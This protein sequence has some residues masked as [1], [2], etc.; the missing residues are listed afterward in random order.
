V[1]NVLVTGG[2][3]FIGSALVRELLTRGVGVTVLDDLSTG[4][5]ENLAGLEDRIR[6]VRGD[7]AS[8]SICAASMSGVDT[9]FHLAAIASVIRSFG[10]LSACHEVNMTGTVNLMDAARDAGARRFVHAVSAAAFGDNPSLPLADDAKAQPISPY[11]LHKLGAEHYGRILTMSG[12]LD[13]VG[14]RYFNIFGPRQDPEGDYAAVIP[15]FITRML[16]GQAPIIFGDG[17]QTRDFL[18]VEDVARAN[19]LAAD[20][21]D[22]PGMVFNI[23]SGAETSLLDLVDTLNRVLGTELG[24]VFEQPRP[25]EI[26]RSVARVESAGA[27]LGF[28]PGFTLEAGLERTVDHFRRMSS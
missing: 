15:K 14:L 10:E 17:T 16:T 6:V 12:D 23:A 13:V 18:F 11:G 26:H 8:P 20:A 25:G 27:A 1:E 28:K 22:A 21:L 4:R 3:G 24:P 7:I 5:R 2:F 19:C 9:V